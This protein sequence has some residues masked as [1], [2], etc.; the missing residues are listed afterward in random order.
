MNPRVGEKTFWDDRYQSG[1]FPRSDAPAIILAEVIELAPDGRALDVATGTGRQA[2]FLA[3]NGYDVDAIDLS[4]VGLT[5]AAATGRERGVA[6]NWI[7]ADLSKFDFPTSRYA[8][9][10]VIGYKDLNILGA[11]ADALV[12]GGVL[13]Y[14][15]HLGP[16]ANAASG[17]STDTYRFRHNELLH[18][19][20]SLRILSYREWNQSGCDDSV[21]PRVTLVAR[22]PLADDTLYMPPQ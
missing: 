17:P 15:H 9:S 2:I 11:L 10:T 5:Q 19:C 8:L 18:A 1:D 16:A 20:L 22:K 12:P 4:R 21:S 3:E 6:V 14:E 13:V 7:Q